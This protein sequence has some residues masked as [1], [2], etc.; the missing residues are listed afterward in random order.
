MTPAHYCSGLV[1]TAL[2]FVGSSR[3][4]CKKR[5]WQH[6]ALISVLLC[7]E[8]PHHGAIRLDDTPAQL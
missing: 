3:H 5:T 4:T 8:S 6:L 1:G 7:K 2:T